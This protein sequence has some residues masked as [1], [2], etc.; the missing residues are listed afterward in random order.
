MCICMCARRDEIVS[1]RYILP[2]SP[3]QFLGSR[4]LL[5]VLRLDSGAFGFTVGEGS[6]GR[7]EKRK[8]SEMGY[9]LGICVER[10][11]RKIIIGHGDKK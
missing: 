1:L 3:F 7:E 5:S 4:S 8:R 6:G 11:I 9:V 2:R 10:K